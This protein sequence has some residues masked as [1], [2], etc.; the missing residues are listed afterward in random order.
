MNPDVVSAATRP[1]RVVEGAGDPGE[2]SPSPAH[3][4]ST[5]PGAC[6]ASSRRTIW[7]ARRRI[8]TPS[9]SAGQFFSQRRGLR[10]SRR[11]AASA[12]A[13]ST[14][15]DVL[16]PRVYSVNRDTGVAVAANMMRERRIHRLLVIDTGCWSGSSRR[17][18]CCAWSK[19][20]ADAPRRPRPCAQRRPAGS[21]RRA[22]RALR[23]GSSGSPRPSSWRRPSRARCCPGARSTAGPRRIAVPRRPPASAWRPR[24]RGPCAV[25]FSR[26]ASRSA[27]TS[28]GSAR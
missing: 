24:G 5:R 15:S 14:S 1:H 28:A 23:S 3:R 17:S 18:I 19:H 12:P 27:G 13:R 25:P 4:S 11:D 2:R 10:R 16:T 21:G 7:C 8:P 26:R 20:S 6:S 22:R 9:R